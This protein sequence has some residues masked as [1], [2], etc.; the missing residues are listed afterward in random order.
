MTTAPLI[1]HV[2]PGDAGDTAWFARMNAFEQQEIRRLVRFRRR[3]WPDLPDGPWSKRPNLTYPH[4]LPPGCEDLAFYPPL[5][6][7]ILAYLDTERIALHTEALNLRS[8]QV[9]CLNIL[10]PL[11]ED[12]PLAA[13]AFKGLLPDLAE[14]TGIEFEYTGPEGTTRWLGE[15]SGGKRGQN[16]TSIDA[17][18]FWRDT[19]G[20]RRVS[21]IEWKYTER[22]FGVCS[23]FQDGG[24]EGQRRC[25]SLQPLGANPAGSCLLSDGGDRR[26]RRYWEHMAEAGVALNAFAAVSGC[27]FAGPLYQLM[28]Q[29]LVAAY[30]VAAREAEVAEVVVLAFAGN[31]ALDDVPPALQPLRKSANDT[32]VDVWNRAVESRPVRHWTVECLMEAVDRAGGADAGWRAYVRERYGV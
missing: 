31:T 17:A 26:K 32:V 11:A 20:R 25:R 21:L 28:R 29:Q 1:H 13:A 9:A 18:L 22:G 14:V 8:S 6:G 2:L 12:L 24:A 27:P 10:F 7:R 5:A 23:A 19:S 15:P 4:I 16:R 3:R 30:T